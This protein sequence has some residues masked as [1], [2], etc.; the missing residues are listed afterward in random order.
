MGTPQLSVVLEAVVYTSYKTSC[1]DL[2]LHEMGVCG[3]P[4]SD[5][6]FL[7]ILLTRVELI[8]DCF[9]FSKVLQQPPAGTWLYTE[10]GEEEKE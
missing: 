9:Y 10:K 3:F 7:Q 6:C 1:F 8:T 5:V 2:S 4:F